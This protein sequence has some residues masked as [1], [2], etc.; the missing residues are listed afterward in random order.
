MLIRLYTEGP[1]TLGIFRQSANH[2]KV[3]ELKESIDNREQVDLSEVSIHVIGALLKVSKIEV[4]K[5]Y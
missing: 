1:T 3:K 5:Q 4:Y 2:R